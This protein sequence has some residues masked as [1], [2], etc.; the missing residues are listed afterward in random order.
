VIAKVPVSG[1]SISAP[2]S[3]AASGVRGGTIEVRTKRDGAFTALR[4][5]LR[6]GKLK[7]TVPRSMN[8][9]RLGIRV[10]AVDRAGNAV[11][12]L[13]TSMSLST[14]IG[15]RSS[16]KVQN[17]R[18]TV[19][20]GR[21]VRVHGRLTS[22]DGAPVANQTIVVTGVLRQTGAR[23]VP[24]ATTLTDTGGRFSLTVPAGP[25][26]VISVAYTGAGGFLHRERSV[27]LR[28]PASATIH[29]ADVLISGA[30]SVRFSGRLRRLGTALPD[31]GK[32]VDLQA[33]A[34]GRWSTVATTRASGATASWSARA[35]FRGTPGSFPVRLR[36][37]REAAFPYELGYSPSISVRVR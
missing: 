23:A 2:V 18:A 3:D 36:I 26:R 9:S 10:S 7:A 6:G 1:R 29:A 28:V 20:Y 4:T 12:S 35:R 25:S 13:V 17:A 37:R 11:S 33:R 32:I 16:R 8:P 24:V 30:G 21:A 22:T 34:G 27:A 5:T 19:P 15:K 14:R 31:G